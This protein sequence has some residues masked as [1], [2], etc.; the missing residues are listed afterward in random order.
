MILYY[1]RH[2]QS[3]NNALWDSTGSSEGRAMTRP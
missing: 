2:A 3:A 1:I